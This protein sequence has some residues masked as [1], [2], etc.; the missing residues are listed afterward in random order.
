MNF[1]GLK[2][3]MFET[4]TSEALFKKKLFMKKLIEKIILWKNDVLI[5]NF[6][7]PQAS[8]IHHPVQIVQNPNKNRKKKKIR[9]LNG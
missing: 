1:G 5:C 3:E 2:R 4:K 7:F 6:L 9:Q 8:T